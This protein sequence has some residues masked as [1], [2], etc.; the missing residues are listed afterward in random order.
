[1]RWESKQGLAVKLATLA[2]T[3]DMPHTVR[4]SLN[5]VHIGDIRR[6][7][8]V[9]LLGTLSLDVGSVLTLDEA[10]FCDDYSGSNDCW[11]D[12]PTIVL[13]LSESGWVGGMDLSYEVGGETPGVDMKHT[14]AYAASLSAFKYSK[15]ERRHSSRD[16]AYYKRV[17][18]RAARRNDRALLREAMAEVDS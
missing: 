5:N 17:E 11:N 15:S 7:F 16:F 2:T 6:E 4:V 18:A 3:R 1:M 14:S 8:L 12:F 9:L 10:W 13:L